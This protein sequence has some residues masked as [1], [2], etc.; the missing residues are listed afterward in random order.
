MLRMLTTGRF[1]VD[2]EVR[3]VDS[4]LKILEFAP[5]MVGSGIR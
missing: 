5:K 2:L 1:L 4:K 3:K